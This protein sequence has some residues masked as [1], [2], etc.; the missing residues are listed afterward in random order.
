MAASTHG[1]TLG[2]MAQTGRLQT[3]VMGR[4]EARFTVFQVKVCD[5]VLETGLGLV[6]VLCSGRLIE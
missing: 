3:F 6:L 1:S 4:H 2:V 5:R